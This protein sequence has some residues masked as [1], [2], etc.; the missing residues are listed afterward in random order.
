M[1]EQLQIVVDSHPAPG[2]PPGVGER[3]FTREEAARYC[4][5]SVRSFER[6][7][8]PFLAGLP[9]G[10][11]MLFPKDELDRWIDDTKVAGRDSIPERASLTTRQP[12]RAQ[13]AQP[14]READFLR[15]IRRPGQRC[16]PRVFPV[17]GG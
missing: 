1:A 8:R 14:P 10:S 6:H 5:V 13:T 15:R 11:R 17:G 2:L 12:T 16:S 4:R 3:L 9:I 7:V